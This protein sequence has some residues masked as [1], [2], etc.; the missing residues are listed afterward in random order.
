MLL[1]APQVRPRRRVHRYG[2]SPDRP[3]LPHHVLRRRVPRQRH[4]RVDGVRAGRVLGG[5]RRR[6]VEPEGPVPQAGA[7]ALQHRRD[8]GH[9]AG[10]GA[11]GV[12]L[13]GDEHAAAD[14]AGA[15]GVDAP[16]HPPAAAALRRAERDVRGA[17]RRVVR[18]V[19]AGAEH[20]QGVAPPVRPARLERR[21]RAVRLRRRRVQ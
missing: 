20:R 9:A 6:H 13:R 16:R 21:V 10:A 14:H 4:R 17:V 15:L 2:P 1:G 3:G 18:P 12:D 11:G 8:D 19:Q 7:E 5:G